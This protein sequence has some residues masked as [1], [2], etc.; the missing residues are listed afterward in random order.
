MTL[1]KTKRISRAGF[2]LLVI[3]VAGCVCPNDRALCTGGIDSHVGLDIN[4]CKAKF[5]NFTVSR[6]PDKAFKVKRSN[7]EPCII[8]AHRGFS[9]AAP[10]NTIA[11]IKD[12]IATGAQGCEFDVRQCKDGTLIV[13]HDDT[14]D[15]TTNGLG[16]IAELTYD[17]VK[18]LDAGSWKDER[19]V[20]EMVPTLVEALELFKGSSCKA[21]IEIKTDGISKEIV[22]TVKAMDMSE[23]VY[24]ASF[25]GETIENIRGIEP[26]L[27][28]MLLHEIKDEDEDSETA[29]LCSRHCPDR[30]WRF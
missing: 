22:R 21:I 6:L 30:S 16:E 4:E 15:R 26:S 3:M 25:N 27:K 17:Q 14:V 13:I 20:G 7:L 1:M 5:E 29:R 28:C 11:A 9:V 2:C 19:F 12:A 18:L 23:Q 24:I 8:I 10:E